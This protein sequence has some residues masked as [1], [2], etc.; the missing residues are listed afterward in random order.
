MP[1]ER[2]PKRSDAS[3][4]LK[5]SMEVDANRFNLMCLGVLCVFV[6]I[7]A[8]CNRIGV[9]SVDPRTMAI[10]VIIGFV[11]FFAPIFV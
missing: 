7:C 10:S 8:I 5:V 9:F 2:N 4:K 6:V 3:E 11:T 1:G